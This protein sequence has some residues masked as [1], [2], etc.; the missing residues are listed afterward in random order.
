MLMKLFLSLWVSIVL[1]TASM[2]QDQP[3]YNQFYFNPYLYNPAFLGDNGR[4]E[5]NLTYKTQW[6][7]NSDAPTVSAFN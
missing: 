7:E 5:A 4:L 3:V 2:G 6:A 1:F